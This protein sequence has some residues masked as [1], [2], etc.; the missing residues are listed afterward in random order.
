MDRLARA[1]TGV[2]PELEVITFPAW[3]CLPYDRASPSR[4]VM[5]HRMSALRR[6]TQ[7]ADRPRLVL[8]VSAAIQ[9][10]VPPRAALHDAARRIDVGQALEIEAFRTFLL[11]TG[12]VM[13]ERVDEPG[14]AAIRGAVLDFFPAAGKQPVR[15]EFDDAIIS[16]IRFYD[17][18]SQR[19][20]SETN[21]LILEPA[22]ELLL[23][24]VFLGSEPLNDR[25]EWVD[26]ILTGPPE[27]P[28]RRGGSEQ[29]LP[30][31]Y[32]R[33]ETLASYLPDGCYVLDAEH[34]YRREGFLEAAQEAY[35]T[36]RSL[37]RLAAD[38]ITL[39][40]PEHL[41]L[42]PGEFE[43]QIA[44]H[45]VVQLGSQP[46]EHSLPDLAAGR[47]ILQ[48]LGR[49]LERGDRAVIASGKVGPRLSHVIEREIGRIPVPME[50][51]AQGCGT[52]PGTVALVPVDLRG[53]FQLPGLTVLAA[54]DVLGHHRQAGDST[55]QVGAVFSAAGFRL[56][57]RV[58]HAAHGVAVLSSLEVVEQDGIVSEYLTLEFAGKDRMLVPAAAMNQLWRYGSVESEV[59]LDRFEGEAWRKRRAQVEVD[60]ESVAQTLTARAAERARV[61]APSC[62]ASGQPY[63]RFIGR[64]P[65]PLTGDQTKAIEA[66]LAD[67]SRGSP[68]MDRLICGDVGYGKTEVAL[69]AAAVVGMAGYQ[70]ALLAPTTIL[71][72]QHLHTFCR[73]FAKLGL[74]IEQ[75]S[76]LA[77]AGEA[78]AVRHGLRDGSVRIV[79]G[80]H[81]LLSPEIKFKEL[82]LVIIDE[83]Q[84]FGTKQKAALHH[85]KSGIHVLT[86]SAT[87]IPR[88]LGGALAGIQDLSVIATPPMRRQPVQTYLL[89]FDAT[90]IREALVRERERGGR[91]FFVCPRI[92]DIEPMAR[93]LAQIVPALEVAIAHGRM[94]ADALDEI[95]LAFAEGA[96][97]VLL[98]TAIV[99]TG[100]DIPGADTI[101]VW[102][103][104]RF[105]MA[106][107]HQLRGRVGRG[108]LR[109]AA[110]LLHEPGHKLPRAAEN[111]LRTL[112]TFEGLGAGFTIAAQD[113]DF[114][115]AGNLLGED[116]AGHMRLIG[117]ELYRH[118]LS[119]ALRQARGEPV[120]E[121]WLPELK[122]GTDYILPVEYVPEPGLRLD[123][124]ARLARL[125]SED[126]ADELEEEI[127]DRFGML[128]TQAEEI[129][130]VAR[131][132]L[133]CRRMEIAKL[134]AGPKAVAATF[135]D[136]EE[137]IRRH[138]RAVVQSDHLLQWKGGRLVLTRASS[139]A[140]ERITAAAELVDR[141]QGQR[142]T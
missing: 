131:L 28:R 98:T 23:P 108:R 135:R 82:G 8:T 34:V 41:Y 54:S 93:Q 7:S 77:G 141:L 30:L 2:R 10:R 112:E 60:L 1:V 88:T 129:L 105:G 44:G 11:S 37:S 12:Y 134:E 84:R 66:T 26:Q 94:K 32:D 13:D 29:L 119:R 117:T 138:D 14:E 109:G 63:A 96:H 6:L 122:L 99:E 111:R 17:P 42:R 15:L 38:A 58:V 21:T 65:F 47:V 102:R 100:L 113:L 57:D 127:A 110:Y 51:W 79:I 33:L 52:Q 68:P 92:A 142:P 87:P 64:F 4:A 27:A 71:V 73:R 75:L 55:G 104:E 125:G 81:A 50:S 76:R 123:L 31:A 18:L 132:N 9:Q 59:S 48:F 43:E 36:W 106:Q 121:D 72:R 67:L 137:G 40:E 80:T 24:S 46:S 124:Y 49:Q 19:S 86:M 53:G 89:P 140:T 95:V 130:A 120:E 85:L 22:S 97:D 103:P 133:R 136:P 78:R 90:V 70:V 45:P 118:L 61:S 114:R 74:R 56:G 35:G 39:L 83:E 5:G 91:S 20:V 3:D 25:P 62:N 107:L 139:S 116:Q 128:P 115:G 126:E 101:I 69:R 16:A